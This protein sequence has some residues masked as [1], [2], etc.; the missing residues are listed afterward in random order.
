MISR[1]FFFL[2]NSFFY[3]FKN[4]IKSIF[5]LGKSLKMQIH[6]KKIDLTKVLFNDFFCPDFFNFSGLKYL[7]SISSK[8]SKSLAEHQEM[9]NKMDKE[10]KELEMAIARSMV[11]QQRLEAQKQTQNDLMENHMMKLS[12]KSEG[13]LQ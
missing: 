13:K 4:G 2:S 5:E 8:I 6:E 11:D 10:R 12:L 9:S 1:N 3:S 7:I